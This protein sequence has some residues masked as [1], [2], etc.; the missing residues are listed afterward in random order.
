MSSIPK[1]NVVPQIEW[2]PVDDKD[3]L[4]KTDRTGGIGS[5]NTRK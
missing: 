1:L 4:G 2:V 5:T 3:K